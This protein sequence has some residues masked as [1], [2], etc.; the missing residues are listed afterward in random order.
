MFR[1]ALILH[2]MVATVLMGMGVTAVLAAGMGTGGPI[3]LAAA[4]GFVLSIP[5]SWLVA[6]QV[7]RARSGG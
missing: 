2:A 6:R 1:L 3:M 5:I 4:G 7:L